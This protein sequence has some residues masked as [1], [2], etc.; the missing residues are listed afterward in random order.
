LLNVVLTNILH[1]LELKPKIQLFHLDIDAFQAKF[2]SKKSLFLNQWK[3]LATDAFMVILRWLRLL[4]QKI[5]HPWRKTTFVNAFFYKNLNSKFNNIT[6]GCQSITT[7][8]IPNSVTAIGDCCFRNYSKLKK[9]W[10]QNSAVSLEYRCFCGCS[11]LDSIGI[12]MSV[13]SIDKRCFYSYLSLK[14]VKIQSSV[15]Q[16]G[17]ECFSNCDLLRDVKLFNSPSSLEKDIFLILFH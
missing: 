2:L 8:S 1:C 13:Q 14:A 10:I 5:S 3:R 17:F 4:L 12:L 15:K 11:S 9:T 7:I 6:W 16:N